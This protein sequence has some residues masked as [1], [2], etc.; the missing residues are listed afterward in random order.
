MAGELENKING[1]QQ[2]AAASRFGYHCSYFDSR[3]VHLAN[4]AV[5]PS[6]E[7][8]TKLIEAAHT[9]ARSLLE[10]LGISLT[11][12]PVVD[13][14]EFKRALA[15]LSADPLRVTSGHGMEESPALR[16]GE[17]LQSDQSQLLKGEG[18]PY[19]VENAMANMG[20]NAT[21]TAVHDHLRL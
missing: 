18:R 1:A 14:A 2:K 12:L 13:E 4:L 11:A 7:E 21:A 6:D 8:M 3:G 10:I 5:F 20:I 17:L 16:L 15:T 19:R 9:E